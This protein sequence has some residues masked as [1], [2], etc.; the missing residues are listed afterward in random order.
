MN[1]CVYNAIKYKTECEHERSHFEHILLYY[2]FTKF[3][4]TG[5]HACWVHVE[6]SRRIVYRIQYTFVLH[7]Y[8]AQ[9]TNIQQQFG[10]FSFSLLFHCRISNNIVVYKQ[11]YIFFSLSVCNWLLETMM[12]MMMMLTVLTLTMTTEARNKDKPDGLH[13]HNSHGVNTFLSFFIDVDDS[14]NY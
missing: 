6:S 13:S 8:N 12:I 14:D 3:D 5:C 10:Y 11:L 1:E 4:L 7:I 2:E 9:H